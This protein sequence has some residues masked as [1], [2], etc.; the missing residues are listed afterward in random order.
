MRLCQTVFCTPS[1]QPRRRIT[2]DVEC[3][4][5]GAATPNNHVPSS[6][7]PDRLGFVPFGSFGAFGPLAALIAVP[8]AQG[9]AGLKELGLRII[10]WRVKW[11]RYARRSF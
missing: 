4:E 5:R 10:R 8:M 7:L 11:Y 6:V 2:E 1:K 9:V 3:I